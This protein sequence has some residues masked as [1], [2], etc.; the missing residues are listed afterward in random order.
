[1][2]GSDD[3]TE[4]DATPVA[5]APAGELAPGTLLNGIY[6]IEA[7][8]GVGGMGEVYRATNLANEEEDAIKIIGRA[9]ADQ[10][11]IEA[12]FRKEARVLSRI[13]SPAVAQLKVFMRDPAL[14]LLYFVTDFVPGESLLDRLKRQPA[15]PDELR[16]L[17]RRLLTGL[18]AVH[19]AGAV[20]RDLSPDNII[21]PDGNPAHAKIIDF[22]IA[23]ELDPDQTTMI[24]DSF[25][26]KLGYIAPEQLGFSGSKVGPWTDLYSLALV[27]LAFAGG[28]ALDMGATVGRAEEARRSA[29]DLSALP[30]DLRPLFDRLLTYDWRGRPSSVTEV[31]AVL[32]GGATQRP[33]GASPP[34]PQSGSSPAPALSTASPRREPAGQ[35]VA[36]S[37][38]GRWRSWTLIGAAVLAV[39]T[40][41]SFTVRPPK[42]SG[43]AVTRP[44]AVR[45]PTPVAGIWMQGEWVVDKEVNGCSFRITID[46]SRDGRSLIFTSVTGSAQ[47]LPFRSVEALVSTVETADYRYELAR[48]D[49]IIGT[50]RN[51]KP[52]RTL[53]KC[54]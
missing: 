9:R 49:R 25:A 35:S 19:E 5:R 12:M 29:I 38:R 4:V 26:G 54:D 47:S 23:K 34:P 17:M 18:Q 13:R 8:L 46:L 53:E 36:G 42:S 45:T 33:L 52:R 43:A 41:G 44:P 27:A 40:I 28:E 14:N 11:L 20:H 37:V 50:S 7:R 2:A 3:E 32:D 24:G 15:T 31:F 39:F 16:A 21:L 51:G 6:R 1:M 22:G 48:P 10:T 30:E